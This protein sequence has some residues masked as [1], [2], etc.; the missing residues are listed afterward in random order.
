[1]CQRQGRAA[2]QLRAA[3]AAAPAASPLLLG[4]AVVSANVATDPAFMA[5]LTQL[6]GVL[7]EERRR[8]AGRLTQIEEQ[9]SQ[10][11]YAVAARED[12]RPPSPRP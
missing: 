7:E 1:M 4:A 10:L 6:I 3:I 8:L 9:L 11:A 12:L 2:A 5:R